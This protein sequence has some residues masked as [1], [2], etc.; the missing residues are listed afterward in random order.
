MNDELLDYLLATGEID[1][2][3]F[4]RNYARYKNILTHIHLY[5]I[6]SIN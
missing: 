3:L 2:F 4:T 1:N 5:V 6:I